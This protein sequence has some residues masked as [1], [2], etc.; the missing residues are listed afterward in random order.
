[1]VC[2]CACLLACVRVVVSSHTSLTAVRLLDTAVEVKVD[3]NAVSFF[4]FSK[5]TATTIKVAIKSIITRQQLLLLNGWRIDQSAFF[6]CLFLFLLF[7]TVTTNINHNSIFVPDIPVCGGRGVQ[8]PAKVV[9]DSS[10]ELS[11]V[12]TLEDTKRPL[13]TV[14]HASGDRSEAGCLTLTMLY[15]WLA[16]EP[17]DVPVV[18]TQDTHV[19][20]CCE[21]RVREHSSIEYTHR[22]RIFVICL[23]ESVQ[24]TL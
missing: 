24:I 10:A 1:M 8:V 21:I 11:F 20:P 16:T 17:L 14:A 23:Q 6:G 22:L 2:L 4:F 5:N 9:C 13:I 19:T 7:T 18:R 15:D 3:P 12:Y